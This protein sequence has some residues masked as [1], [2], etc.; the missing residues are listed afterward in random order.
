MHTRLG[1]EPLSPPDIFAKRA[2]NVDISA[3]SQDLLQLTGV[4]VSHVTDNIIV[5]LDLRIVTGA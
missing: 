2:L 1:S 3:E 5:K 4:N